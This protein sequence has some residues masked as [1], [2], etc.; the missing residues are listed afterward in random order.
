M[1]HYYW[2]EID[3]PDPDDEAADNFCN[4]LKEIWADATGA[5]RRQIAKERGA[6]GI[7]DKAPR[8]LTNTERAVIEAFIKSEADREE[9]E[10]KRIAEAIEAERAYWDAYWKSPEGLAEIEAENRRAAEYQTE[11]EALVEGQINQVGRV[12]AEMDD[13]ILF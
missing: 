6:L 7:K 1:H 10:D 9:N 11:Y 4:L 5:Q 2:G 8:D 13:D 12:I 3:P